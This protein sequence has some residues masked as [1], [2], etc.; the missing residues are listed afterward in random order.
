MAAAAVFA[1]P[2]VGLMVRLT[3]ESASATVTIT[4]F[5]SRYFPAP[6]ARSCCNCK[7]AARLRASASNS[8]NCCPWKLKLRVPAHAAKPQA[9]PKK[10][11]QTAKKPFLY[12]VRPRAASDANFVSKELHS[13]WPSID[14]EGTVVVV[15]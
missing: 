13:L 14:E 7:C 5:T 1:A 10:P 6:L 4:P 2:F 12:E 9:E 11:K 3:L 8:S 15:A